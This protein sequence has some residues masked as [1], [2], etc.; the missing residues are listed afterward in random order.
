MKRPTLI[1][2]ANGVYPALVPE[3][4]YGW[5]LLHLSLLTNACLHTESELVMIQDGPFD[6][7]CFPCLCTI[8]KSKSV[9]FLPFYISE[10]QFLS[11]TDSL[12]LDNCNVHSDLA[13]PD[14]SVK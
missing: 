4:S 10:I 2:I 14:S 12:S 6:F 7:L 11:K 5:F 3:R 1:L 8:S 9:F 13:F